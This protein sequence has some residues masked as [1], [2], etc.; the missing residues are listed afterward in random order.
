MKIIS[1][2]GESPNDTGAIKN[3][4]LKELKNHRIEF[5][6]LLNNIHGSMLDSQKTK[7]F[8]RIEF[9]DKNPQVC[10]IIRDLDG[11]ENEKSKIASRKKYFSE[12]NK[13]VNK[14]GI[15]LL[16]IYVIEALIL[17][18]VDTF[19]KIYQ[20]KLSKPKDPMKVKEP[21]E[22]L[23]NS[24]KKSSNKYTES[25][26]QNIFKKL[27]PNNLSRNCRYYKTFIIELKKAI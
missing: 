19:N 16:N 5:V 25:E 11:L 23:I 2:V 26:N 9:E 18:D 27:D 1:L 21:K 20:I 6:N 24:T 17:S 13:I 10:I 12:T 14:T 4:L 22:Y 15:F 8:L 3:L 7:R